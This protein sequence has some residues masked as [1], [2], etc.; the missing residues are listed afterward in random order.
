[1]NIYEFR[2]PVKR[3]PV[4]PPPPSD[5]RD[6]PVAVQPYALYAPEMPTEEQWETLAAQDGLYALIQ[7]YGAKRVATWVR[8]LSAIQGEGV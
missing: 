8:N 7:K 5:P 1:M 6:H 3:D 2:V 4:P